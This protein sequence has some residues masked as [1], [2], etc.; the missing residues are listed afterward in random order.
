MLALFLF[1]ASR[2]GLPE[3]HRHFRYAARCAR[4]VELAAHGV[5]VACYPRRWDS[6]SYYLEREV[7]SF[8]VEER[9]SMLI[10]YLES[11]G[12]IVIREKR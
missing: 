6:V 1:G 12:N 9:D 10:A 5:A 4:H 7:A 11:I 8:G 2:Y 3:Y